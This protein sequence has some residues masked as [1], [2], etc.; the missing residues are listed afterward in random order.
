M[1]KKILKYSLRFLAIII[2]VISLYLVNLFLMKPVSIDHYLGKE[3]ILGLVDSPEAL[4][5]IGIFDRYNWITKHNSRLSI[6]E[7]DDLENDIKEIEKGIKTL[8]K[9]KD[10]GLSD[11]QRNTKEIAIFDWENNLEELKKYPYHDYPLNQIGGTHLNTIE[12]MN[13]MHPIRKYSEA[14]DFISRVDL[15]K[16]V[17]EGTLKDLRNKQ[18]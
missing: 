14:K 17:Y 3:L 10:S 15:I 9:Y 7:E 13:S 1:I 12:F 16:D 18:L 6:P 11:I 8:Y 5:Y 4:T 2:G